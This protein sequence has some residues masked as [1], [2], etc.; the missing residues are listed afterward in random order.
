MYQMDKLIKYN[1]KVYHWP[2][3]ANF[4]QITNKI[5]LFFTKYKKYTTIVDLEKVVLSVTFFQLQ[6]PIFSILSLVTSKLSY[7][8]YQKLNQYKKI[9][10]FFL[11]SL[12]NLQDLSFIEKKAFK[13]ANTKYQVINIYFF[14]IKRNRKITKYFFLYKI[15]F[16]FKQAYNKYK[17]FANHLTFYKVRGQQYWPTQVD[18]VE[19]YY[20]IY[21]TC[22]FHG[23]KQINTNP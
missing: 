20:S 13:Q 1:Y 15:V 4:I 21:K 8:V 23:L 22:Q 2:Y 11:D 16:I 3:K 18:N 7:Q 5:S 9:I 17:H 19:Q 6:L 14:Y 12:S 10:S